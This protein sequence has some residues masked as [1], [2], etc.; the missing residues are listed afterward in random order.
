MQIS[1]IS[2]KNFRQFYGEQEIVLSTG[3][4]NVT[5]IHAEN[6]FGKTS[7]LNAVLW[8][9]FNHLTPKFELPKDIVNYDAQEEGV[10]EAV[11][12][13]E[14]VVDNVKYHISRSYN[15]ESKARDKTKLSAFR[16][17]NGAMKPLPA[18]DTFVG[19]VLP[20]EMA[21][22]FFFDGEGA[23]TFASARNHKEIANSIRS[24]LGCSLADTAIA[25]LKDL[26]KFLNRDIGD[27]AGEERL[28]FLGK[29]IGKKDDEIEVAVS[30]KGQLNDA[31][32][33]LEDQLAIINNKLR[34]ADGAQEF[35][36][37]KEGFEKQKKDV[38]ADIFVTQKEIFKWIGSQAIFVVSKSLS[39]VALDFVDE[40]SL[41]GKI[42]SP[43]NE[44]FVQNIIQS[45]V[46]V[47]NRPLKAGT[48]EWRAV[49]ELLKTASN[50]EVMSRVVRARSRC[51][52]L[53][54][55]AKTA[56]VRLAGLR[57]RLA[58]GTGHLA[59][60]EQKIVEYDKKLQGLPIDELR[61]AAKSASKIRSEIDKLREKLGGT[62]A[63]IYRLTGEK[64]SMD[65]ELSDLARKNKRT[66]RLHAK[67]KLAIKAQEMLSSLLGSY[68][69]DARQQIELEVNK[70]LDVVSHKNWCC[71]FND[72]FRIELILNNRSMGKSSGENQLLSLA[73]IA[74]LVHFA[75]AR[76]DATD[77]ILK[78]G[79]VAPLVL[80]A[81]LGQ[82]DESYQ[83]G[84]G[85][86]LPRLSEQLVLLVSSSQGSVRVLD[87]LRPYIGA[88]YVLKQ[89]NKAPR[90]NKLQNKKTIRGREHELV[91]YD[92]EH[93]MT[94]IERLD[95]DAGNKAK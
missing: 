60:Y 1:K 30:A 69:S 90:G 84:V 92:Q 65:K 75:A 13:V 67:R 2:L 94:Y 35:Q 31:I 33:T 52:M 12:I 16:I 62:K 57:S 73:F 42:P 68:E 55:D 28:E 36:K 8:C 15:S 6:G 85:Q 27:A 10:R 26:C 66:S 61:A 64:E 95:I 17:D 81:P 4:A 77:L 29:E 87:T 14:I 89:H 74:S 51:Q 32:Q 23:E 40:A 44:H 72:D 38:E 78:P 5:L 83:E 21:K 48:E 3:K 9:M 53:S 22:Y 18:P 24:I 19:S 80:D 34:E 58:K 49:S 45:G 7:I 71:K 50:V 93:T 25:D 63:H 59:E 11:V 54:S 41:R 46:C 82:L 70:I 86:F 56:P 79:I 37:L 43:Y 91:S 47:C 39:D 88:E 20:L 76:V